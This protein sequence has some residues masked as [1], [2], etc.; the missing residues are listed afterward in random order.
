M[1]PLAH[2]FTY[3]QFRFR[4]LARTDDVALFEKSGADQSRPGYEVVLVQHHPA[5]TIHGRPYPERESLPPSESWGIRGWTYWDLAS[6]QTRFRHLVASSKA[7]PTPTP[8][9]LGAPEPVGCPAT[10]SADS[11][12][13]FAT[14]KGVTVRTRSAAFRRSPP[15]AFGFPALQ[16]VVDLF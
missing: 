14:G 15:F 12:L 4:L 6:A 10:A 9:P 7:L 8:F 1:K 3:D 5:C 2:E 13:R 11:A 16:W